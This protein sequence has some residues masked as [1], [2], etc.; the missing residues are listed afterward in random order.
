MFSFRPN[1]QPA[2]CF[3]RDSAFANPRHRS[4]TPDH[5]PVPLFVKLWPFISLSDVVLLAPREN[6]SH[7]ALLLYFVVWMKQ[8]KQSLGVLCNGAQC[9]KGSQPCLRLWLSPYLNLST[10]WWQ[11]SGERAALMGKTAY[12]PSFLCHFFS[13]YLPLYYLCSLLLGFLCV[14]QLCT[15]IFLHEGLLTADFSVPDRIP[16]QYSQHGLS[17]FTPRHYQQWTSCKQHLLLLAY[18]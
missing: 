10:H 4:R 5:S 15:S 11:G 9:S 1:T 3:Q 17:L 14:A 16:L 18:L 6:K 2:L 7:L 12:F 8:M 13:S